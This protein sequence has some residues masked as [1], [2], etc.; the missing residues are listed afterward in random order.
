MGMGA[1][2]RKDMLLIMMILYI[3]SI[4]QVTDRGGIVSPGHFFNS[5]WA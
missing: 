5:Y 3:I 2:E 4:A 1:V